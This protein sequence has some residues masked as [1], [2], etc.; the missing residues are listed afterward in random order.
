MILDQLGFGLDSEPL[1]VDLIDWL[2]LVTLEQYVTGALRLER[3]GKPIESHVVASQPTALRL[4]D[5]IRSVARALAA[6][7][8]PGTIQLN[9][10]VYQIDVTNRSVISFGKKSQ[11][12][13]E[14]VLALPPRLAPKL[15]YEPALPK[16]S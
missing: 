2:D 11:S 15:S 8:R 14:I 3:A 6:Q 5:G 13:D 12:F 1:M 16:Q 10:P 4:R 7:L 9:Q